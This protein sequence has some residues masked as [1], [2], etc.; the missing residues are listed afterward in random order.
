MGG[1]QKYIG[2]GL[3]AGLSVVVYVGLGLLL[4]RWLG[5]LPW[6]TL[7]GAVVGV[8]AMFIL[9]YRMNVELTRESEYR[10]KRK[11]ESE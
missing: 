7:T 6:L 3:Q 10:I 11:K 1:S 2:L 4:D 9:F 5:T 8:A